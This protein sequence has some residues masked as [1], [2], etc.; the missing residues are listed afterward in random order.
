M[1]AN[2]IITIFGYGYVSQYLIQELLKLHYL[3]YCTSRTPNHHV[4]NNKNLHIMDFSDP[5][6]PNI[7]KQSSL[8]LS[9]VP[10]CDSFIDPVLH[11]YFTFLSN[12]DFKWIGYLS[13]T[14]IY[15][16]HDGEWVDEFSKCM[17]SNQKSLKR[18]EAENKWMKLYLKY[19]LPVNIFRLS[20]IYGPQRNC[21]EQID[22]GKDYT[23]FKKDHFFSRIH[24]HDIC[25]VIIASINKPYKGEI[26][27]LSDDEPSPLNKVQQYGAKLLNQKLKEIAFENTNLSI[28]AKNFFNDNKKVCNKKIKSYLDINL[29]YPNYKHGLNAI[30][31]NLKK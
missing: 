23:I 11:K 3:I 8:V 10:P 30:K 4:S 18:L 15:G 7:L 31:N 28:S 17:P 29:D 13:S 21:I 14:S 5:E 9:T 22:N 24:V 19:N 20:G 27:N 2:K 12:N 26:F 6:I 16:D 1:K 25:K